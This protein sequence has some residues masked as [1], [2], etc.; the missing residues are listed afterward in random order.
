MREWRSCMIDLTC[1]LWWWYRRFHPNVQKR[2]RSQRSRTI[3]DFSGYSLIHAYSSCDFVTASK[4]KRDTIIWLPFFPFNSL[5]YFDLLPMK[6]YVVYFV[7][8]WLPF[9]CPFGCCCKMDQIN[10][11]SSNLIKLD[12]IY[13]LF[14]NINIFLVRILLS[15]DNRVKRDFSMSKPDNHS[16]H[17]T[18]YHSK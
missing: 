6:W 8:E 10:I 3:G 17:W 16:W 15:K 2:R 5:L 12:D 4:F 14:Q 7:T 9:R 18:G 11:F 13:I 1:M